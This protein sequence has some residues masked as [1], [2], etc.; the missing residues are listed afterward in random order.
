M[1]LRGES[2]SGILG[3]TLNSCLA[4]NVIFSWH[5]QIR[6]LFQ[7]IDPKL[8]A[9]TGNN[10]VL[11]MALVDQKRLDE[12]EHDSGFTSQL[13]EV[14]HRFDVYMKTPPRE[15][16]TTCI[17]YFSAEFGLTTCVPI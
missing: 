2:R 16:D 15:A 12:L 3:W 1:R 11:L 14:A 8:W 6:D 10:P 17:A 4:Y 13:D 9:D 7:R 5:S